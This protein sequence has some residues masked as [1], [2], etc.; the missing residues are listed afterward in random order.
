LTTFEFVYTFQ[1]KGL[2]RAYITEFFQRER[3]LSKIKKLYLNRIPDK[4]CIKILSNVVRVQFK[5]VRTIYD[6]ITLMD[7]HIMGILRLSEKAKEVN[8]LLSASYFS[9]EHAKDAGHNEKE[10]KKAC[11]HKHIS[12]IKQSKDAKNDD[13]IDSDM[14]AMSYHYDSDDHSQ[15]CQSDDEED[16]R[17]RLANIKVERKLTNAKKVDE[18]REK[19][20]PRRQP[21]ATNPAKKV[22]IFDNFPNVCYSEWFTGPNPN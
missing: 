11:A 8:E 5:N 21:P 3:T 15:Y 7:K 17:K 22:S 19:F 12:Y 6:L 14:E 18:N 20:V 4:M 16:V 13:Y 9:S 10:K 2:K 1:S